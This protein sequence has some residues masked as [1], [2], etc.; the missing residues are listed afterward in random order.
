MLEIDDSWLVDSVTIAKAK[1]DDWQNT[2]YVNPI[3]LNKVRVDLSKQ[4]SGVGNNREIV[5]NA[6]VFLFA[7]F[8]ENFF[9]PD[10]RWLNSKIVY[11][12]QEFIVKDYVV[13]HEVS[14]NKPFSVELKVI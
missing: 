6:T 8:T 1:V 14:T 7:A 10:D 2:E 12:D 3:E 11:E 5:A 9:V 4:Y 13:S